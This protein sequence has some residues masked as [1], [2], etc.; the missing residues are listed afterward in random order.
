M[1]EAAAL[2]ARGEPHGTVVVADEQTGGIG[3]HGHRWDSQKGGLYYSVILRLTIPPDALPV[4]TMAL[5]L[6]VQAA[7]DDFAH[8]A[9]DLRWPN[10][11]MLNERK[12]AGILVQSADGTAFVAGIGMNVNQPAFPPDLSPIATSLRIETAREYDKDDLLNRLQ[13]QVHRYTNLLVERG[14]SE[15]L[16]RFEK[17]SSYVQGRSVEVDSGDRVIQGI[18]AGLDSN[19]FLLVS[20]P[21]GLETIVAGGV[22]PL[23]S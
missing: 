7:I 10:D 23:S 8:V 13:P 6:A 2:A 17:H 11:V 15:I 1:H 20:T 19:G 9:T 12:L 4:L 16:R 18:T 22:R 14:K 5:G 3:R 21:A